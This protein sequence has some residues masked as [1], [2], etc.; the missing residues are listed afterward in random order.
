MNDMNKRILYGLLFNV[1]EVGVI[2]R[3]RVKLI[4]LDKRR[5]YKL[6]KFLSDNADFQYYSGNTEVW[7]LGK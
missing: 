5:F 1:W 4:R 6:R 7:I 2:N 3:G